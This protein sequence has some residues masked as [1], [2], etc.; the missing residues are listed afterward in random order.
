[1]IT[2]VSTFF[3]EGTSPWFSLR[4]GR[5]GGISGAGPTGVE[6]VRDDVAQTSILLGYASNHLNIHIP[7]ESIAARAASDERVSAGFVGIDPLDDSAFDTLASSL[8][9]GASGVVVSPSDQNCRPTHERFMRLMDECDSRRLPVMVSNPGLC[10][11][12]SRLDFA[13]PALLDEAAH[14]F[15]KLT[16]IIGELRV[17]REL[18]LL[19]L[20]RHENVYAETSTLVSNPPALHSALHSAH[21][22]GVTD[23]VL[24]GSGAPFTTAELAVQRIFSINK[25]GADPCL[26]VPREKLREIVE[27]DSLALLGL[28]DAGTAIVRAAAPHTPSRSRTGINT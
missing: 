10:C 24:F 11:A 3:W 13:D 8:E 18:A 20:A 9:L 5:A 19:M 25:L 12:A 16:L 26:A 7:Y 15:P 1:V 23:K 6:S 21:H 28:E 4:G 17:H 22:T 27:R 14:A 2:D